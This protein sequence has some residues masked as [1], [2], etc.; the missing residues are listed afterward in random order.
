MR[1]LGRR[2]EARVGPQTA[3]QRFS[4]RAEVFEN[5]QTNIEKN[6]STLQLAKEGKLKDKKFW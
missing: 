1:E 2:C 4:V 5:S 6:K 3:P